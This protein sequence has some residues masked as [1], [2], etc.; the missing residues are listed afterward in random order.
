MSDSTPIFQVLESL[1]QGGLTVTL[2]RG[3]DYLVPGEWENITS[4]EGMVRSVSGEDD[5]SL[6]Q[7]I[8]ERAL[9]LYQD[10]G[11][12]YQRAVWLYQTIDSLS[13][14]AGAA[15]AAQK[16]GDRF[17]VLH[18][19][20]NVTP[21]AD[22][23]QAVDAGVKF[24]GELAAFCLC[25]GIPGDSVGDFAKSLAQYGKEDIMRVA[26]WLAFDCILPLGPDFLDKIVGGLQSV[27]SGALGEHSMFRKIA[28]YLPGSVDEQRDTVA[29]N[30]VESGSFLTNFV[31]SRGIT[32]Q[33]VLERVRGIID[34]TDDKLDYAAAAI[35]MTT[36]YFEHTGIQ[37]VSR[38]L[39]SRAY[40]EI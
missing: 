34:V 25:N 5:Q 38:R 10:P 18:F 11:Q 16:L 39:I 24:A 8:G 26:C 19:L 17:A 23:T 2:L 4:F 12:G 13:K 27:S 28:A 7:T 32:Q 1:P 22:T 21:K 29:R 33:S 35:D 3:F 37:T 20:T 14:V 40:G 31:N 36:N 30:I 6:I 9:V 15:A